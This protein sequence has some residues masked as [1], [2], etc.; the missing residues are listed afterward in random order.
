MNKELMKENITE[1]LVAIFSFRPIHKG[2]A[3]EDIVV[4]TILNT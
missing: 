3:I 4:I 2:P 1:N